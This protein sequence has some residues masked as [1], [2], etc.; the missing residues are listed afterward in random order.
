MYFS[1]EDNSN[2]C[3]PKKCF[4]IH[5]QVDGLACSICYT[6]SYCQCNCKTFK[7]RK[8][9]KNL[10]IIDYLTT[11]L[12]LLIREEMELKYSRVLKQDMENLY[13]I[14]MKYI[15]LRKCFIETELS[16]FK[17]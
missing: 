3:C 14:K 13:N 9:S 7:E 10:I 5:D 6:F 8:T 12:N 4:V 11:Q 1:K 17:E 15:G 16:K 2:Y